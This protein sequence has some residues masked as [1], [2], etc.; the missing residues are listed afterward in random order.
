MTRPKPFHKLLVANRGEIAV[1]IMKTARAM[2]YGTVAVYS[3]ADAQAEHVRMAD[4]AVCIGKAAPSES[5]LKIAA[6]IDAARQTGADAI[7]PGYG[8]LAE[9]ED[10]PI[11]CEQ[12]GIVFVG[13]G[14]DAIRNMGDKA[15]AKALMEKAGVPCVPGYKGENQDSDRL[16]T[17]AKRIGFPVMIKATA[18]GG[19]RGMRLVSSEKDFLNHL[20]SAKSEARNAFGN[21]IVLLEKAIVNPRHVEIQ[22]MADKHGN[23]IHCGERDCSVQRRHQKVIE[24]APSPAVDSELR[25]RMGKAS[26]DAVRAIGYVGAGTFEYL[27]DGDGNFYFME[28]NTRLQVEHPVTEMITGLDL[29]ELQLR[30]AAGEKLPLSQSDVSYSGHAIEVR[31]CAEDPSA[32]F[33]PQSGQLA[34]WEPAS[35]VRVDHAL[36]SGAEIPPFYD[37]M[38]A[39][40]IGHGSSRDDARRKLVSALDQTVAIGLR[41]NKNFLSDCLSHPVFIDGVATTAFIADHGEDLMAAEISGEARAAMI[42]AA[43]MRA[44]PSNRLT[45]GFYTPLRLARGDREFSPIVQAFRNGVCHVEMSDEE[46]LELCVTAVDGNRITLELNGAVRKALLWR[47]ETGVTVHYQG[48]SYDFLD[49]TFQPTVTAEA[50]G[51]DGKVRASMNGNIVLVDIA[52]GDRVEKGQK[53]VVVEAMKM[54]HTHASMVS[55]TVTAVNVTKGMQ[56]STHAILVE[57]DAA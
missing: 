41:T 18:G 49:L 51:G 34:L 45:H 39:K 27:L 11:A 25:E 52:V 46:P 22:V 56:V 8:F 50:A 19:G 13:P 26:I 28:M 6:I 38:I 1:R 35:F 20:Q 36:R 33:M 54:E 53:L 40:I 10:L 42:A 47:D 12:A 24:E 57:I 29:V 5:Y 17:E 31:L 9:N 30:A 23:A 4:E 43:L 44:G 2:G 3:E 37:S 15:G 32:G 21:D 48:R 55:G 16:L 7:H 14:A